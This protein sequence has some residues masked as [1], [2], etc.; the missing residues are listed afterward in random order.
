MIE[1]NGLAKHF[2]G[3][4]AVDDLNL[5]VKPGEIFALLGP[6]GAGKTTTVRMLACLIAPTGGEARVAGYAV[7]RESDAIRARIGILTE[8][9]GLYEKL[10][11]RQNLDFFARLYGLSGAERDKAVKHYLEM[12][13]L[14]ERRDE[15]VG[16]FS[17]G[18]K[19]KL[20]IARA[21]LHDPKVVFLDEPTSALDPEAAKIVRDFIAELKSEGH[22]IFLCTHNLDEAD[23]LADRIGVMKQRLIQVDTPENL[24]RKLYGRHVAVR[25]RTVTDTHIAA[26]KPLAFVKSV[27]REDNRLSLAV[28]DP[29]AMTPAVV[30]ALVQ[31]GGEIQSVGEEKHSLEDVYLNLVGNGGGKK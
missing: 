31:A 9:P 20:A 24:R 14:W 21:L 7:G 6:N 16:G 3:T 29:D 13:G 11:A 28:D 18:M 22:T 8:S 12:L 19:Q 10:S 26:L 4:I 23:R 17:K 2:N 1:T 15:A 25:M 5:S 30:R 27:E